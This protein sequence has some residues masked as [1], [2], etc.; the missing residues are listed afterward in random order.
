MSYVEYKGGIIQASTG[1]EAYNL[2]TAGKHVELK[3]HLKQ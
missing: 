2:L 3:A 1:C